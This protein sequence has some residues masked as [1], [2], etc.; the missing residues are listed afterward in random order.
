MVICPF[1]GSA[2]ACAGPIATCPW[3]GTSYSA[4]TRLAAAAIA[5]SGLPA[6]V[7]MPRLVGM[8]ERM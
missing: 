3:N 2:I 5:A 7:G 8:A 1:D 6:T 4:S